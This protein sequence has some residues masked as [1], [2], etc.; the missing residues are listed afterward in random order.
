MQDYY[1]EKILRFRVF[2]KYKN[3]P[4]CESRLPS[5]FDNMQSAEREKNSIQNGNFEDA[6]VTV[7]D[8]EHI[9]KVPIWM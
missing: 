2:T 8:H 4:N 5:S 6:K 1:Y 3:V 7:S 9:V